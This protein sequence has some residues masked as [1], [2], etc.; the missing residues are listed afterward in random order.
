MNNAIQTSTRKTKIIATMGPACHSVPM[1]VKL[2]EQGVNVFR[3]N[4]SHENH[5]YHQET[6]ELI[7]QARKECGK[8]CGILADLQGP[9][10]RTGHTN[11]DRS[12]KVEAG[13]IM[14]ITS[15][16]CECDETTMCIDYPRLA[17]EVEV[18]QRIAVN[19]GVLLFKIVAIDTEAGVISAEALN[20]G[21]YSSRKG[22][23]LPEANL[24]V[25]S[26]TE[27][28]R[29]D[30]EWLADKDVQ[31]I[32][33][34]FVRRGEDI[35]NL[36]KITDKF[37]N[38]VRIISKIEKPEALTNIDDILDQSEGIM[39]ARGDLGV[40]TSVEEVPVLQK[41][42]ITLANQ[43]NKHVIVATQM[44]E[45][46]IDAPMPTRA[47]ANDVANAILDGTDAIMLSGET[48]IGRDPVEVIR[49]MDR[50]AK[51]A[52]V[53]VFDSGYRFDVN[54]DKQR[55]FAHAVIEAAVAASA[56]L[57]DIP[58]FCFTK[59]GESAYLLS[60][61]HP[62]AQIW[63]FSSDQNVVRCMKLAYN[64]KS[65]RIDFEEDFPTLLQKTLDYFLENEIYPKDHPIVAISG[66]SPV[67]GATNSMRLRRIGEILVPF[68]GEDGK[69]KR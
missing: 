65:I 64:I 24:S 11:N 52:E 39:I 42:L 28:D 12:V 14:K 49:V 63:A 26:M 68:R 67:T 45:S 32:A 58:I 25:P 35:E 15:E 7:A 21:K 1:I 2:L 48:A 57:G 44:L 61:M 66:N 46:M 43:K 18:G 38:N 34:S 19:D 51:S 9:K 36:K 60:N 27:K 4:M 40:E 37:T 41:K 23:N 55:T 53:V 8:E 29:K 59:S 54:P 69:D 17:E 50:I 13:S 16:Q 6:L 33:L 56:H 31:F 62:Q 10:I 47:E 30:L 20:T 5:T 22:V 3:M